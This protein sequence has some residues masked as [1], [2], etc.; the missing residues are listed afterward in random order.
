MPVLIYMESAYRKSD[1]SGAVR[2]EVM[3]PGDGQTTIS[4]TMRN[5]TMRALTREKLL[6]LAELLQNGVPDSNGER[7]K[8]RC[9][10][11][12]LYTSD[13]A[14][15][16]EIRNQADAELLGSSQRSR[17]SDV[18]SQIIRQ[19]REN[20]C[21]LRKRTMDELT[22]ELPVEEILIE[23]PKEDLICDKCGGTF[24]M[25][26]KKFVNQEIQVIPRRCKLVKYYSCTYACKSCEE[27]TGYAHIIHTVTPPALMKHSLASA[28]TVADVMTRK[29]VDGLPLARQEKIW[30]REGIQLSRATLANW[31]IQTSQAWLKPLYRQMKKHLLN[32][33]VVHADETVVQVL[34]EEGKPATSESRMWVYASNDRSG[35]PVRFF[36]YQP[37]RSGKHAAAFL[38]G[39]SGCLVT[40]GYSGYNQVDGVTRCGC[41][42][43]MRRK[44]REAMPKEATKENSKAAVGYDYCN[45]LFALER[46]FSEMSDGAR[47]TA[48]QVKVE[49]LLDAYWWWL[50]KLEPVPGSK[51]AEA[52]T[53]AKNQKPYLNAFLDHGEVDI[54][55]NFAENAIRPFVVG[56]KGWLFCDSPKGAD[57]SAIVYTL[58]ETAK[59]N[60][61]DPY[62]YLERTLTELPYLGKNPKQE[63]LDAFM[64][65]SSAMHRV[66]TLPA[67]DHSA[68][69]L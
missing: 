12:M 3:L 63:Y 18:C 55:N 11:V 66:C 47:K 42:A 34:K 60:G 19:S 53:Y 41:W 17:N 16:E 50:E 39:F 40:D 36:E 51:L 58:V 68:G 13:Q 57:S 35:K 27:K 33:C 56:R 29:Y 37:N 2:C 32:C 67:A 52:V 64:P 6:L 65:W 45:K 1:G 5:T 46:K 30:A 20:G 10:E 14:F 21:R 8:L 22:A 7:R 43:H 4:K 54:S 24:V 61:L 15:W 31:V 26:G 49:P 23:L 25:I 44:W 69:V 59:A 48:R 38:K 28:S 62:R 9:V